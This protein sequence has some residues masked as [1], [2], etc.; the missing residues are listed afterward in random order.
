MR[1]QL[2]PHALK[3][4]DWID[5]FEAHT[6]QSASLQ[7]WVA[8]YLQAI[9]HRKQAEPLYRQ[10]LA[11]RQR[12]LGEEH[13]A[14]ADSYNNVAMNLDAQGRYQEAEP[15]Y[16]RALEILRA[17]LP[18]GHPLIEETQASLDILLTKRGGFRSAIRKLLAFWKTTHAVR[19]R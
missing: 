13:P 15:L 9:G 14:T 16:R 11:I 12:V 5:Q 10:A 7:D 2:L 8:C 4:L 19:F 1:F 17:T 18:P 6:E 3:L